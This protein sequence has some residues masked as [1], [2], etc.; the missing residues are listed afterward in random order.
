MTSQ[1]AGD[2]MILAVTLRVFGRGAVVL[3]RRL[4]AGCELVSAGGCEAGDDHVASLGVVGRVSPE[5]VTVAQLS[6]MHRW[7]SGA[8][9]VPRTE[10]AA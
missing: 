10:A 5:D 2:L 8:R 9:Q 6:G 1:L 3:L 7:V 4:A